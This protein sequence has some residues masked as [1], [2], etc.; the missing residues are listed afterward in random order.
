MG[1]GWGGAGLGELCY[2][3]KWCVG[4]RALDTEQS[5]YEAY[6]Y[7]KSLASMLVHVAGRFRCQARNLRSGF[8][9]HAFPTFP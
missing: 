6:V 5:G 1:W 7:A 4:I 2:E 9:S 3:K 8:N